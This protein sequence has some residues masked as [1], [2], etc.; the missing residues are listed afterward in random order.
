MDDVSNWNLDKMQLYHDSSVQERSQN[1]KLINDEICSQL[2]WT[3]T[4]GI[5]RRLLFRMRWASLLELSMINGSQQEAG[6]MKAFVYQ[7]VIQT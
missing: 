1:V 6:D 7:G 3:Q 4:D 2:C 5:T